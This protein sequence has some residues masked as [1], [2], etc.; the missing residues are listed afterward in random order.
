MLDYYVR[1][2]RVVGLGWTVR[3]LVRR[4]LLEVLWVALLPLTVVGHLLGYRRVPINVRRIGHLACE[5]DALLKEQG[6]GRLPVRKWFVV[7]PEGL[8]TNPCLL[9]YW[10]RLV[11][12]VRRRG[13][14]LL[15]EAMGRHGLMVQ[16]ND[17]HML[18][19]TGRA[20]YYSILAEWADRPPLL[21]LE[22][23]H[24]TEGWNV[25]RL[26]GMPE[27]AWFVCVH[28]REAGFSVQ[29]ETAHAHRNS[30]I[31]LLVPAMREIRRRGGWIVRMGDPSMRP[32]PSMDG[33]IDYAL[34]PLR[35]DRMDVF[36]CAEA[37][38]F[39]G[40]T[41]GL[42]VVATVFG[43]PSALAN[44]VPT[45]HLAF[46]P[47]DISIP[48]LIWSKSQQRYLTFAELFAGP[49]ANFRLAKLFT[50]AGLRA[51]ENSA[52]DLLELVVEMLDRQAGLFVESDAD[53]SRQ[54]QF[55]ALLNPHHYCHGTASSLGS[56]F[57]ERHPELLGPE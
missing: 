41:S 12:V 38:F 32:L 51:D 56:R 39:V 6:L 55:R 26:M 25:L 44:M 22:D 53:R 8:A 28:A 18:A 34:H 33:V 20:D 47:G 31:N 4:F 50:Q 16:D 35:S 11:P 27:G 9:D 37:R 2:I 30:D 57:L 19:L 48:K 54:Q 14:G 45:S 10:R 15:L 17:R 3:W 5:F 1:K 49:A 21:K 13:L 46:A 40:N 29:D 43:R 23:S 36:L 52:E 7:A 42:F 24:R